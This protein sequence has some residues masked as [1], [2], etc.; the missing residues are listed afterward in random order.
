MAKVHQTMRRQ[1]DCV[2][3]LCLASADLGNACADANVR[4]V[5]FQNTQFQLDE[6][7]RKRLDGEVVMALESLNAKLLPFGELE[8][9]VHSR[10]NLKLDYDHYVRKVGAR[11]REGRGGGG[12]E[13]GRR[14][15]EPCRNKG[16]LFWRYFLGYLLGT[17]WTFGD[18]FRVCTVWGYFLVTF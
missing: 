14:A 10:N 6:E 4:D 17:F 12:G 15:R 13:G 7:M 18:T 9:M 2:R 11:A 5:Q 8:K 1:L 16:V 3:A